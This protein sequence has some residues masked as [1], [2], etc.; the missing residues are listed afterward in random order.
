MVLLGRLLTAMPDD[1]SLMVQDGWNSPSECHAFECWAEVMMCVVRLQIQPLTPLV[2]EFAG[3]LFGELDYIQ[4]GLN[5]E[6]FQ[7]S[8]LLLWKPLCSQLS[9]QCCSRQCARHNCL[10][11]HVLPWPESQQTLCGTRTR[12]SPASCAVGACSSARVVYGAD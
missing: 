3:R 9:E 6:R 12:V 1:L 2:D 8:A 7:V 4:E 10:N 11:C 5:A